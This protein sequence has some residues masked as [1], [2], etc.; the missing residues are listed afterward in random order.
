MYSMKS[1]IQSTGANANKF[2]ARASYRHN[3]QINNGKRVNKASVR[4]SLRAPMTTRLVGSKP[5][6]GCGH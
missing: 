1:I 4:M 2:V 6:C 3:L 5:S